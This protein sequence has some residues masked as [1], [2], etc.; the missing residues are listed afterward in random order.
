MRRAAVR[1]GG[2]DADRGGVVDLVRLGRRRVVIEERRASGESLHAEEL[3]RV[4]GAIIL[5]ELGVALVRDLP[6]LD[7]E[8]RLQF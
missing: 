4:Q 2:L 7:V 6:A 1:V 8:H 3:L 5:A